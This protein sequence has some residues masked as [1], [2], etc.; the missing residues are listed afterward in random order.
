MST[1]TVDLADGR[2]ISFVSAPSPPHARPP[3]GPMREVIVGA[4]IEG[5]P[6]RALRPRQGPDLV[7]FNANDPSNLLVVEVK[8][9]VRRV[10]KEQLSDARILRDL[11][12]LL[13][14]WSISHS[15]V[16]LTKQLWRPDVEGRALWVYTVDAAGNLAESPEYFRL[17]SVTRRPPPDED[18]AASPVPPSEQ[19]EIDTEHIA[20]RVDDWEKRI[21]ALYAEVVS[22]LCQEPERYE[23]NTTENVIMQEDLMRQFG[24]PPRG[25]P[26]LT[27]TDTHHR[28][29]AFKPYALWTVG[30]NGR[31]DIIGGKGAFLVDRAKAFQP[32]RW[33]MYFVGE[34]HLVGRRIREGRSFNA[35]ALSD[36]LAE[37]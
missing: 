12:V 32:P 33:E 28:T 10:A 36:L 31:I 19:Q 3:H 9:N 4:Q 1:V 15:S 26:V 13:S 11:A 7:A 35:N 5:F 2:S 16:R 23:A 18:N 20:R 14:E 8:S 30:G 34:R 27:I 21:S 17:Q 24:V 22:W 37:I 25:L 29:L 6:Q